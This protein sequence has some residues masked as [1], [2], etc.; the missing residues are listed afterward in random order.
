MS[1]GAWWSIRTRLTVWYVSMLTLLLLIFAVIVFIFQYATLTKQIVHDE[2]QDVATVEGLLYFDGSGQLHLRQD[3]YSRPQSHLLVDRLM[4]V[5]DVNGSVLYRSET[6]KEQPLGGAPAPGEGEASANEH[7]IRL[8]DGT[9]V[10]T[11]S[12]VHG[13]AGRDVVIRLGYSLRP[14]RDRMWQFVLLLGIALALTILIATAT[15][16]WIAGKAISPVGIMAARAEGI[17]A[18]NLHDRLQV[19]NSKDELG[20]LASVFN[21]LLGRLEESFQQLQRFTADAAHELRTPLASLRTVGEVTLSEPRSDQEY[22][23]ALSSILE[24]TQ[25]L[26]HMV[27]S[28]LLLARAEAG[29]SQT[30]SEDIALHPLAEEVISMLLVLAE[31]KSVEISL[32]EQAAANLVVYGDRS[33]LRIALINVIHN[34][35]KFSPED[36]V[37]RVS[38]ASDDGHARVTVSDQGPGL[39]ANE[40]ERA[41]DR[42]YKGK[43]NPSNNGTGLGL[44]IVKLIVE[45]HGG[46]AYFDRV[47]L[48]GSTVVFRLPIAPQQ[49]RPTA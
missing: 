2:M 48:V 21:H 30:E 46:V 26:S 49:A 25:R 45:R 17:T 23:D 9:H 31:E 10:L 12:H 11:I 43:D 18:N 3:Y 37:V 42:F 32:A 34:A 41:F 8:K 4:E 33:L 22:R 39:H 28:L 15:G 24:E 38:L 5:V 35:I 1:I 19:A 13:M 20:T 40:H 36:G 7:I 6:L 16:Q 27:D 29:N 14:L 47:T 44:S